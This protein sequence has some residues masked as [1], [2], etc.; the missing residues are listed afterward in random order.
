MNRKPI[1]HREIIN[2]QDGP[3]RGG[4]TKKRLAEWGVPWPPPHPTKRWMDRLVEFG[5]PYLPEGEEPETEVPGAGE[6]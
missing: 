2:A 1:T 4:W 5:V 3:G 6:V